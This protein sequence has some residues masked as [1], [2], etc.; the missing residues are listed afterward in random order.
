MGGGAKHNSIWVSPS[1]QSGQGPGRMGLGRL[2]QH[3]PNAQVL[4]EV[5]RARK[6]PGLEDI[7]RVIP[8]KAGSLGAVGSLAP[9]QA[10]PLPL[11]L[12]TTVHTRSNPPTMMEMP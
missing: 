11:A 2:A 4:N 12:L 6:V 3:P 10:S 5:S 7:S 9:S 8:T 1:L